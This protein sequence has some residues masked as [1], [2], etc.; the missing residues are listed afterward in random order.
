MSQD[1]IKT[2]INL[3][4]IKCFTILLSLLSIAL[5]FESLDIIDYARSSFI[6][7]YTQDLTCKDVL[8][9]RPW[10]GQINP[11]IWLNFIIPVVITFSINGKSSVSQKIIRLL[12]IIILCH[13]M[14]HFGAQL[15]TDIRNAPFHTSEIH[16]DSSKIEKFKLNCFDIADGARHVVALYFGWVYAIFYAGICELV[17]CLYYMA[18]ARLKKETFKINWVSYFIISI[19]CLPIIFAMIV[20]IIFKLGKL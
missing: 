6:P 1:H 11:W 20:D 2:S 15:A 13:V 3:S 7:T 17:W 5:I 12:L 8:D 10:Y 16:D 19:S 18:K 9:S 4:I 14:I